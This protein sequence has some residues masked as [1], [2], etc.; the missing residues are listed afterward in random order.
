MSSKPTVWQIYEASKA[1]ALYGGK[2]KYEI[3]KFHDVEI[4][5]PVS[6]LLPA[7]ETTVEFTGDLSV[8][9]LAEEMNIKLR[10][11]R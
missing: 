10:K 3:V 6:K 8:I 11:F 1:G 4:L 7:I 2:N 5:M 9:K